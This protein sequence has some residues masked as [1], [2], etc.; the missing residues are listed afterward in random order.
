MADGSITI[1]QLSTSS[2]YQYP[3]CADRA[4][5]DQKAGNGRRGA[6]CAARGDSSPW[7]QVNFGKKRLVSGII[8]QGR[9]D[10]YRQWVKTFKVQYS[11]GCSGA[12]SDVKSTSGTSKIFQGNRDMNTKVT[13][14]FPRPVYACIVRI[15]PLTW[16]SHCS[17]RFDLLE[18]AIAESVTPAQMGMADG[19]ITTDKLST[20]SCYQ[21][22]NCADRARLDQK[23]GNGRRGAWCAARGD[24]SPWIQVN[25][26]K[27]TL[28]SGIITQGRADRYRQWV[29]TFKVQYS[30]A[31]S[32]ALSDVKS[33]S[34][35]A[36]IFQ[37]NR[38]M[39]TKVTNMFP[40]PLYAC[41][42]RILPLTWNSHCSMRFDL[43]GDVNV[44]TLQKLGMESRRIPDARL[45]ASSCYQS[46]TDCATR[47]RL[48][49]RASMQGGRWRRGAWCAA[50]NDRS[51]WIQVDLRTNRRIVG[52]I[53]QGRYP[54]SS[55]WVTSFGIQYKKDG[56]S[57]FENV[58][59][60]SNEPM[61]FRGNGNM[62]AKV[63]NMFPKPVYACVVRILPL[64][65]HTHCSMRFDLLGEVNASTPKK[66]GMENR[67]IPNARLSASSCYQYR[68]CATRARLNHTGRR[69]AGR[70]RRGAWCAASNDRSPWVQVDLGTNHRIMGVITQ[71]RYPRLS[72]WVTSFGIQYKE[73]GSSS[74]ENV[75]GLGNKPKLFKGNT[76]KNTGVTNLLP[77]SVVARYVRILPKTW[78]GHCSMRFELL[79][80]A[81]KR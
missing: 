12:L 37:G 77:A 31:C 67:R 7:I 25:F 14:M 51:P 72:Q 28:V 33:S 80:T 36:K 75:V 6:W 35:T 61:I 13:N 2:C 5:L 54:H 16:N 42:V 38:D 65:C 62:K 76:D 29:K 68:D 71:G 49:Q 11:V 22:P 73:D 32:G 47:A 57:R 8:T 23:A 74:F 48:N 3:N 18:D 10:R 34:R 17:M 64:K 40:R 43:L 66:L 27:Q 24:S 1:D 9:A 58:V 50:S 59:G 44:G 45:S 4:R 46:Y 81:L 69:Q 19:S 15:L 79:G 39:N 56:A 41:I 20:S 60:I 70:W 30:V 55:Q 52:V 78:Q 26:G 53:T 63:T 21:Y